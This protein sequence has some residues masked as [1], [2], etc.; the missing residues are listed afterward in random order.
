MILTLLSLIL[1]TSIWV[2]GLTIAT[3]P[4]MVFHSWRVWAEKKQDK[5]NKF[6]E[7]VILCHFCM[8]SIHSIIGYWFAIYT[9]IIPYPD[10]RTFYLYPLV[11]MGSSLLNGLTW[12][13][14]QLISS[15]TE[16]YK[17]IN[18]SN[19]EQE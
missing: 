2:L 10:Y 8:P 7:A 17:N 4:F 9:E 13:T 5:G 1:V 3:Q 11:V 15:K 6:M 16:H 19:H 12:A 18:E 14:Y